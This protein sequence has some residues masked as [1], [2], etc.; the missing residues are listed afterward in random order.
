MEIGMSHDLVGTKRTVGSASTVRI[1][2]QLNELGVPEVE[3]PE[4]KR[5]KTN[6]AMGN[7]SKGAL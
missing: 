7:V 4:M 5:Q 6:E 1:V 3:E 2:P